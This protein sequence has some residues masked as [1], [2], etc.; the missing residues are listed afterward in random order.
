MTLV[1]FDGFDDWS[2]F[3][4][5]G[6]YSIG[7]SI[8][9]LQAGQGRGGTAAVHIN[10]F[11]ARVH[12]TIPAALEHAT[13]VQGYAFRPVGD[14]GNAIMT[15]RSDSGATQHV[16]LHMVRA[17]G[18][19][20][21]RRGDG[22]IL[23]TSASIN[24]YIRPLGYWYYIELKV[25][26]GDAPNGV[27]ELRVNGEVWASASSIDTKN[28]GTKTV[29]DTVG[30]ADGEVEGSS[31][32]QWYVE[33]Y[34]VLNGA[35]SAPYN[36]FLGDVRVETVYPN[37]NGSSS[38]FVGS[39]GNSTDNYLLVDEAGSPSMTDYVQSSVVGERDA[40]TMG[41]LATGSG[42]VY[43]VM[44]TL[45]GNVDTGSRG[46][47]T[48]LKSGTTVALGPEKTLI[49]TTAQHSDIYEVNPDTSSAWS[50][51]EVNGIEAGVEVSS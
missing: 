25:V 11:N 7:T 30:W 35:G 5:G 24:K 6:Y 10:T 50:I 51:S 34:Y 1:H 37:G 4:D 48:V 47:K 44:P 22:T 33:D 26:L 13:I 43:G 38:Q 15:F 17:T 23:A 29:F 45:H 27:V 36:N 28:G 20:Q 3:G 39:D 9:T 19:L 18:A 31:Q 46:I 21:V 32:H 40:Y 8:L 16:Y 2:T 49:T 14:N 42:I 12:R 41:D